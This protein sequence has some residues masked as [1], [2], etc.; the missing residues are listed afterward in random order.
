[1]QNGVRQGC[2]ISPQL[3]ILAVELL[4][5]KIIQDPDIQGLT[6]Y[7]GTEASKIF[8]YCDDTSLFLSGTNDVIKAIDHFNT[9]SFFSG[10]HLNYNKC[11]ALSLNGVDFNIGGIPI[12][13]KNTIKILGIYFSNH[14][15][16]SDIEL[17]WTSRINNTLKILGR[18]ARRDLSIIG[19]LHVIKTFGLS[20]FIFVMQ[21]IKIP[22]AVL[23]QVNR[24]FF[25]FLWKKKFNN[26]RAFEKVK[27]KVMFNDHE[28]GG[29]KMVD[30]HALQDSILLNW[31][32]SL[33]SSDFKIWKHTALNFFARLG[34]IE[35]FKSKVALNKLK[36]LNLIP[37][38]FWKDVL[39]CW[40]EHADNQSNI[41]ITWSDPIFNNNNF[42]YKGEPLF[43]PSCITRG[44][45]TVSN[46]TTDG[47]LL[48][49]LEFRDK[50]GRYARSVLDYIIVANVLRGALRG[51]N[52][53]SDNH[54]YFKGNMI[55]NLG[56]KKFYAM[57]KMVV[58]PLC[59]GI[60]ERKFGI[61]VD[62][63][64]WQIIH[65]LKESR[66]KALTWKIVHNIYPTNILLNKMKIS[67]TQNCKF[68]KVIDVM[69]H[70]FFSCEKVK[71]LWQEIQRDIQA[72]LN[73]EIKLTQEMVI[74]GVTDYQG[75]TAEVRKKI[76]WVIAI[77]KMVIS[78]FKYGKPRN[79]LEIYETDSRHRQL[80]QT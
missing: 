51:G 3:F 31:A 77:G 67:D 68:C 41:S 54:I 6:P 62:K 44:I 13:F 36:G 28:L 45:I 75:T 25:R 23:D 52:I 30:I 59:V 74:L 14:R 33:I 63:L 40:L 12:Q 9:F 11:Y 16:A 66:L 58:T 26:R 50:Y 15:A 10:L 8:Q 57:I 21:S 72:F 37:S 65:Q 64:H 42:K 17:N 2:P 43:L 73:V 20:Q 53:I 18:W 55:G 7:A 47:R 60:W 61:S 4:A 22:K 35:V 39:C 48:T 69:E 27:R 56:R 29:L 80:W 49:L 34:G 24:L 1:M 71:P 38:S 70:F 5:Q 32:E 19:K 78:K 46:V 79:I 76:N